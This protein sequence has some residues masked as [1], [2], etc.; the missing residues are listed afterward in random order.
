MYISINVDNLK[1]NYIMITGPT[2]NKL[3]SYLFFYKILYA[4]NLFT[5]SSLLLNFNNVDKENIPLYLTNI[6]KYILNKF[7]HN[8]KHVSL[9]VFNCKKYNKNIKIMISGI[10]ESDTNIGLVYKYIYL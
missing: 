6:E 10:W 3:K 1:Y 2:K 5:M 9:S 8:N 7:N 4:T